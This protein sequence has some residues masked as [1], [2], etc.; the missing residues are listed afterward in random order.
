M[1]AI[2]DCMISGRQKQLLVVHPIISQ[3]SKNGNWAH[4]GRLGVSCP[5]ATLRVWVLPE[6][7]VIDAKDEGTLYPWT[8][9]Y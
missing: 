3:T 9:Q 2:A 5:E 8:V 6:E 1:L 4:D 7:V